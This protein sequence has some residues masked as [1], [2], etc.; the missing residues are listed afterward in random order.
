MKN[1][2]TQY[3][4]LMDL[5]TVP[6]IAGLLPS[7][8]ACRYHA[9]PLAEDGERITVALA[10]PEDLE[11]RQV[12]GGILG[13]AVCFVRA[14]Q[15]DIDRRLARFWE[16][17]REKKGKYLLWISHDSAQTELFG[18]SDHFS[19]LFGA[20]T[21]IFGTPEHGLNSCHVLYREVE[22]IEPD[23]VILS[24]LDFAHLN[25]MITCTATQ[26]LV[27]PLPGS[28]LIVRRARWPIK[29]ILLGL[30]H[31]VENDIAVNWT[32]DIACASQ[33]EVTILA[34]TQPMPITLDDYF[35]TR[36][37]IETALCIDT[38]IGRKLRRVAQHVVNAGVDGK[39]HFRQE[40]PAWQIR[41]ELLENEYDLVI[42]ESG[43]PDK[44]WHSIIDEVID[45]LFSWTELPVLITQ[46]ASGQEEQPV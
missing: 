9:L 14:D 4:E 16:K 41:F 27:K 12:I 20:S 35:R 30:R 10:N 25:R 11:A 38:G 18:Y 42:L 45:P 23:L 31:D 7:E 29:K 37:M 21:N 36:C 43:N 17:E 13:S 46:P 1:R 2:K 28:M 6:A 24:G 3:L 19:S 34:L 32:V 22:K 40:P 26:E 8:L 39:I 15:D 5:E 44:H 33:A